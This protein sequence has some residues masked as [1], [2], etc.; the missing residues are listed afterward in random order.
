MEFFL[1][2][3]IPKKKIRDLEW[4]FVDGTEQ[5]SRKKQATSVLENVASNDYWGYLRRNGD[6][7]GRLDKTNW[8]GR[9]G[10]PMLASPNSDGNVSGL[11]YIDD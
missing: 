1:P 6:C 11:L 8:N 9:L 7:L 5:F 4:D 10:E 3:T 2:Q